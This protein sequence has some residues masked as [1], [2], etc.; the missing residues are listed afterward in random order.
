[1]QEGSLR[2]DANVNL[3]IDYAT[4]KSCTPI[5]EIKNMNSFRAV[6]RASITKPTG[7]GASGRKRQENRRCAETNAWLGR[8]GGRHARAAQ[9]EES[10]DYRYFPDPDLAPVKTKPKKSK[11]CGNRSVNYRPRCESGWKP[12]V[13]SAYDADVLINQGRPVVTYFLRVA[14]ASGDAKAAANWVTQ[15]VL[16]TLKELDAPIETLPVSGEMLGNLI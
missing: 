9:Q 15:D 8:C 6:E 12:R 13:D 3:H 11:R 5:V 16:R 4:R 14:K 7:N 2:V 10:S 1:M